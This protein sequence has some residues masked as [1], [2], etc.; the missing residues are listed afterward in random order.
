MREA[1]RSER[2]MPRDRE[3]N[4]RSIR[5]LAWLLPVLFGGA[6]LLL[7]ALPSGE[8][9]QPP[10]APPQQADSLALLPPANR[11]QLTSISRSIAEN[12]LAWRAG[13][14]SIAHLTPEQFA[15]MLGARPPAEERCALPLAFSALPADGS[16]A[17]LP[18]RWDWRAQGGLTEPREQGV[19]GSCWAFAA[20]GALEAILIIYDDRTCDLSEQHVLD[21]NAE[22]YG[23]GGGWMT[24]AYRLW[25]DRGALR[26]EE[27]PYVGDDDRPCDDEGL[28]ACASV[29][30][31]VSVAQ[32]REELMRRVLV[33]PLAVA[34]HVYPDFQYYEGGVYSH[35]GNDP[36]NH[37]VLLVGWDDALSAWIIKN[38]WGTGWGEEGYA[39]IHYDCCRLGSYAHAI[40]APVAGPVRIHH[41]PVADTVA[42]GPFPV[43]AIVTSLAAPI[44]VAGVAL[45]ADMGSGFEEL[46]LAHLGSDAYAATFA[47]ELPAVS[48]G[49]AVRYYYEARDVEGG[50][51]WLPPAG[52][53][54]PFCFKTLRRVFSD[55]FESPGDWS[56]G[57]PGD[58]ATAGAWEWGEPAQAF[59]SSGFLAQPGSDHTPEGAYCFATGL[60]A[61]Q[62]GGDNDV[63]GGQTTLES[64][65]LDL[66]GL[67]DARLRGWFWFSNQTGAYP[68]EDRF[69]I[70]ASADDG[71]HWV[72]LFDEW[73]GADTWR[74]FDLALEDALPLTAEMRIR[75]VAAD[76]L[77]E[78]T[79]EALIDDVEILTAT[80]NET[81]VDGD[82][83]PD[84]AASGLKFE[85]GPN[86]FK[87]FAILSFT[88][89]EQ[90]PVEVN[91]YDAAGRCV[92]RVWRGQLA[93]GPQELAWD[94]RGSR[95]E[96]V[97]SGR[98]WARL[99]TPWARETRT[100]LLLR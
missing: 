9:R 70:L 8:R 92:R 23:C 28:I 22:R 58:D 17:D 77:H 15:T 6:L 12:G 20:A 93:A 19:C 39:Y 65:R 67:Q 14:T 68:W 56:A 81:G 47:G 75:F 94:G 16:D 78:S 66:D 45:Y 21:C 99:S 49:T 54:D 98:Y 26:E 4:P 59:G 80:R 35:A 91:V 33:R 2:N 84:A 31:W 76:T 37:A 34:M 50:T 18:A 44:D 41:T 64:P 85:T 52:A 89:P 29:L 53:A 61:S 96:P 83:S 43:E 51:A 71:A 63:D 55:A 11:A 5:R 73:L 100:M 74:R 95:G 46:P 1:A 79:V 25:R 40:T 10:V 38:S 82:P 90:A 97:L 48:L 60:A 88:L 3:P 24:S 13:R 32:T 7:I 86:P 57:A 30:T 42:T 36:I 72:T 62:G 87:D 27:I 69:A